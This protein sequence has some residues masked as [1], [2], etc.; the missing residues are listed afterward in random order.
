MVYVAVELMSEVELK[1]LAC[2]INAFSTHE[3]GAE[4]VGWPSRPGLQQLSMCLL[5]C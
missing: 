2:L 5:L 3:A 4:L 1:A